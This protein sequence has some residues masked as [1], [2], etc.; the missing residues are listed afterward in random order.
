[1]NVAYQHNRERQT[2]SMIIPPTLKVQLKKQTTRSSTTRSSTEIHLEYALLSLGR[3]C[4]LVRPAGT[5]SSQSVSRQEWKDALAHL[6]DF[7]NRIDC[8]C[9]PDR[10]LPDDKWDI[11]LTKNDYSCDYAHI[12]SL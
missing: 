11:K 10:L 3:C 4:D 5:F 6:K 12:L 1:M 2:T 8:S 9:D 7:M